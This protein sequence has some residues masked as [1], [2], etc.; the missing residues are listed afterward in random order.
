[1][2][3]NGKWQPLRLSFIDIKKAYF[4]AIPKRA[5]FMRLPAEMGLPKNIVAR[6]TRCVY[7]TRDA[8]MLWEGTYRLAL[9][10]CGFVTGAA[11]PCMFHHPKWNIQV[12]VHGDDFTALGTDEAID[13]YT[14][15]LEAVFEIKVRGRL[16]VGCEQRE[17]K[18]LNRVVRIDDELGLLYEA[19]PRHTEL[20]SAS[21]GLT[22]ASS[23]KTPGVKPQDAEGEAPKGEEGEVH[24][25]VINTKGQVYVATNIN[26]PLESLTDQPLAAALVM[27]DPAVSADVEGHT[28]HTSRHN[29]RVDCNTTHN[30]RR[31]LC[32]VMEDTTYDDVAPM[33]VDVAKKVHVDIDKNTYHSVLAYSDHFP[34]HPRRITISRDGLQ[35]VPSNVDHF[36]SM[37]ADVMIHRRERH[38]FSDRTKVK[39]HWKSVLQNLRNQDIEMGVEDVSDDLSTSVARCFV[40]C[41]RHF[42]TQLRDGHLMAV[43]TPS[44]K[45]KGANRQGAKAVK[46]LE[47][48]SSTGDLNPHEA[49]MFRA[50]SARANYLAQDRP[51]IALSTKELCRKFAVPNQA[52]FL[53]LKRVVRYLIGLP[54]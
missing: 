53:K 38:R 1:M 31:P 40:V 4:N 47:R 33:E 50:F 36:T 9:E 11:N 17:I 21:M 2:D 42:S 5:V 14:K 19:D 41:G 28:L 16:G 30:L 15:Q 49:T 35:L 27:S 32:A 12:V 7:G 37:S 26:K 39:D 43:R 51:D 24:G 44:T 6:Q 52:S 8:G 18:I 3:S 46:K 29:S 34:R 48:V 22:S 23:V 20:L 13:R 45:K 25:T 54:R 10:Q